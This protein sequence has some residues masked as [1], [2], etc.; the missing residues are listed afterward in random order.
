MKWR[1]YAY[2]LANNRW[3]SLGLNKQKKRGGA[4]AKRK[5]QVI[6]DVELES[7]EADDSDDDVNMEMDAPKADYD[8]D[9]EEEMRDGDADLTPSSLAAQV[10]AMDI[11]G[12]TKPGSTSEEKEDRPIAPLERYNA[13][14]AVLKNTL[15]VYGGIYETEKREYTLDDFYTLNLEKRA[16]WTTLRASGIDEEGWA[17]SD[18]ED[19]GEEEEE[20][21]SSDDEDG[22]DEEIEMQIDAAEEEEED[23]GEAEHARLT[24]VEKVCDDET[25]L[26]F[27]K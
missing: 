6:K 10:E 7:K 5:A 3:I 13:M 16:A 14:I 19:D 2:N 11:D 20:E 8:E 18:D 26:D 25:V 15:Y 24:A 4:K 9:D 21:S 12:S 23:G 17:G 27:S 22:D 1:R